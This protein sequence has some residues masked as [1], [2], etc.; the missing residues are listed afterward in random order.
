MV[1]KFEMTIEVAFHIASVCEK[2]RA[3]AEASGRPGRT[4]QVWQDYFDP[5]AMTCLAEWIFAEAKKR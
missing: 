3:M 2:Q 5:L 1:G 4:R